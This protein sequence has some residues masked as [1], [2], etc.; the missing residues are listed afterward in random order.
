[1]LSIFDLDHTLLRENCSFV[2]GKFLYKKGY[3]SLWTAFLLTLLYALQKMGILSLTQL[4]RASFFLLFYKKKKAVIQRLAEECFDSSHQLL[5]RPELKALLDAAQPVWIASSSPD[6]LVEIIAK[7]LNVIDWFATCYETDSQGFFS[8][9][10]TIMD[11]Q[12]KRDILLASHFDP[13]QVTAYSDSV[14][15][16]PLLEKVG[17]PVAVF[18]KKKLKK[19]AVCRGWMVIE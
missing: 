10:S 2:F 19:L 1:M 16:L 11:G 4:H 6:F 5:L 8:R 17:I 15:D 13:S 7:K 12:K 14:E 3:L 18:P 9:V